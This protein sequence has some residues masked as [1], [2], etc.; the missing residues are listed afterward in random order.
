MLLFLLKMELIFLNMTRGFLVLNWQNLHYQSHLNN[1]QRVFLLILNFLV[2]FSLIASKF[3]MLMDD[4]HISQASLLI[5]Q[6]LKYTLLH[7]GIFV[8]VLY[9]LKYYSQYFQQIS[10]LLWIFL[11]LEVQIFSC[12]IFHRC[13]LMVLEE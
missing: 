13:Y 11:E 10:L 7:E 9:Q 3:A 1:H 6:I 12:I 2:F 8:L 4:R 5:Q